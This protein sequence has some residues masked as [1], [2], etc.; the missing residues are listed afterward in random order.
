VVS[1]SSQ[2]GCIEVQMLMEHSFSFPTFS[3][4]SELD[5]RLQFLKQK[6]FYFHDLLCFLGVLSPNFAFEIYFLKE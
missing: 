4:T 2:T 6:K 3:P 5:E 1:L